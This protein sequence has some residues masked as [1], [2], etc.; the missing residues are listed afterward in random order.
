M[1]A[2][3]LGAGVIGVSTA[4]ELAKEGFEVEVLERREGV[5]LETSFANGGQISANHCEPWAAPGVIEQAL[6]WLG[7]K[8]APLL[9]H[10][11][12][13]P[14]LWAW[15]LRF[16]SQ[17]REEKF[18]AN[19]AKILRLALYSRTALKQLRDDLN[20]EYDHLENGIMNIFRSPGAYEHALVRARAISE[21]GFERKILDPKQCLEIEPALKGISDTLAGG[22]YSPDDETGDAYKFTCALYEKCKAL[23]VSFRFGVNVFGLEHDQWKI[24]SAITDQGEIKADVFVLSLG[25]YSKAAASGLGIPLP[26]YPTK[27]YSVTMPIVDMAAAPSVSI[28]DDEYRIVISRMGNRLRTAG[29][30]EFA[31][32]NTDID[33]ARADMILQQAL[34]VFPGAADP[35]QAEFW[36]ALRPSTPDGA[37]II[38]RGLQENLLINTGHGT[39]GWT[40]AVGSARIIARLAKGLAPEIDLNGLGWERFS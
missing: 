4:Y 14:A 12:L 32:F 15:T 27:G 10:L 3:V 36:C 33:P 16:L 21:L 7:R 31:G 38:G 1:K 6:K 19:V 13:D 5:G 34:G 8:D 22:T 23:G 20:I 26:I 18:W 9:F 30:A 29:T 39:L 11:R 25:S 28:T 35:A 40:M 2:V 37:P 17:S 24:T